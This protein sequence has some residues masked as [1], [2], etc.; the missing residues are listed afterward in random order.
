MFPSP[1]FS[2]GFP[3]NDLTSLFLLGC[4]GG[5]HTCFRG[6]DANNLCNPCNLDFKILHVSVLA[7]EG[8]LA[9]MLD[10]QKG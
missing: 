10:E 8:N 3:D 7:S 6:E 4:Y 2:I 9:V 1:L 5:G